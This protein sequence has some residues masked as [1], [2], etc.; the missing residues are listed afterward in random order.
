MRLES[1]AEAPVRVLPPCLGGTMTSDARKLR[2]NRDGKEKM[3]IMGL[4]KE[5]IIQYSWTKSI[6]YPLRYQMQLHQDKFTHRLDTYFNFLGS[7][8]G[9]AF[10][11]SKSS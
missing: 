4:L 5:C 6:V 2:S 9:L 1:R 10:S 8:L 3:G 7:R 11:H